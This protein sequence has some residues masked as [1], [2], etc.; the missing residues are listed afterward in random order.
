MNLLNNIKSNPIVLD[1]CILMAGVDRQ[2]DDTNYCFEN[3]K[4]SYLVPMLEYLSNIKIH[5]YV[6]EELDE[7]RKNL[8]SIYI[9]KNV[10]IVSEDNLYGKDPLYTTIFNKIATHELFNYHRSD[11]KNRGEIFSLAFAAFHKLPYFSTR[12]G[13]AVQVMHEIPELHN[14]KPVGFEYMLAIGYLFNKNCGKELNRRLKSLYK[15]YCAPAIKK[16][17]IPTT[18]LEFLVSIGS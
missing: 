11:R 16:G 15:V 10:E 6:F 9:E 5:E 2:N 14:I 1:A 3:M 7:E 8:I 18:F 13:I 12:D 4:L 17:L